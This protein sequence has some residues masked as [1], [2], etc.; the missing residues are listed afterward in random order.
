VPSSSD[1]WFFW[2][3]SIFANERYPTIGGVRENT[4]QRR[5][6]IEQKAV[7]GLPDFLT[8]STLLIYA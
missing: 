6:Q 3:T 4:K 8:G 2:S 1:P 7:T 5:A